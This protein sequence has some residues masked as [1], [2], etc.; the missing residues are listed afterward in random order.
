[1]L[2]FQTG[3]VKDCFNKEGNYTAKLTYRGKKNFIPAS[4]YIVIYVPARCTE[5]K[6]DYQFIISMGT[7][8]RPYT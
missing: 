2:I 8:S 3:N 4:T 5:G 7:V 1:M 6:F